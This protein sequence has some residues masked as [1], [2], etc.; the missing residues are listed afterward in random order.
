MLNLTLPFFTRRSKIGACSFQ[1]TWKH[2]IP[3]QQH[4]LHCDS[5]TRTHYE[6]VGSGRRTAGRRGGAGLGRT[7][8]SWVD[9]ARRQHSFL[10]CSESKTVSW[11]FLRKHEQAKSYVNRWRNEIRGWPRGW[12]AVDP[13]LISGTA[14]A[15]RSWLL[16]S[17]PTPTCLCKPFSCKACP[18]ISAQT[19]ISRK[20]HKHL[21]SWRITFVSKPKK[22]FKVEENQSIGSQDCGQQQNSGNK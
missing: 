19:T 2:H 1:T 8:R 9:P 14:S 17:V 11:T 16:T 18:G 5:K 6:P 7:G 12:P 3:K 20:Y 4:R 21:Y 15:L 13:R 22:G 10:P